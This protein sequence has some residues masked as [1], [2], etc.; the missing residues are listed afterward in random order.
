MQAN[1]GLRFYYDQDILPSK[2]SGKENK[3]EPGAIIGSSCLNIPLRIKR[4]LFPEEKI[5]S[6]QA[7]AGSDS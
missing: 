6:S 3:N 2:E 4:Q 5:L 7:C 1:Q